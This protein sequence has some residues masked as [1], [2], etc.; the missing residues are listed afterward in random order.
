MSA[1]AAARSGF[2]KIRLLPL[3][4]SIGLASICLVD[5]R[6]S[7]P[8]GK[9]LDMVWLRDHEHSVVGI[10]LSNVALESF[11]VEN[12]ILA[13]RADVDGFDEYQAV[14]LRLL[15]GDLFGLT[16][17]TL[18]SVQAIYDRA[19]LV[20]WAPELRTR[21]VEHLNQLAPQ[22]CQTLLITIE[23]PETEIAG[24]PFSV[25]TECVNRLYSAH[26]E[27]RRLYREDILATD[28]RLRAR[29][30]TQLYESCFHLTRL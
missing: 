1:G 16:L 28:P 26:H 30:V 5:A 8:C 24:P 17:P 6:F 9:S 27:V 11:C 22:G 29:G 10:E 15:C 20:S 19:A 2:T 13:R 4:R 7:F 18:G 12:G 21:Y 14:D 23:Y 25:D 3:C